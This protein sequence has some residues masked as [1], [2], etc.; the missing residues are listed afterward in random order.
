MKK[1]GFIDYYIDEWHAD[2]YPT[3]I[4]NSSY[5]DKFQ[6]AL[7]WEQASL[8]GKKSIDQW[9]AEQGV[10]KARS[11]DQVIEECDCIVVLSPDNPE[12]HESLTDLPLRSGK[13]VYVDKTFAPSLA[14]ARR[15][16]ENAKA[17]NTPMMTSSALRYDSTVDSA[18]QTIGDQPVKFVSLR[19][20]GVWEIYAIHQ[21]EPL[22]RIIGAGA[23]RLM[24]CGNAGAKLVVIDY[25][26][27]RRAVVNQIPNS[28]FQFDVS[29]GDGG[30]VVVNSM[31]DFFPRFIEAMCAFFETGK[32]SAPLEQTLEVAA[33]LEAGASALQHPDEWVAV[34]K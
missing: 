8:P 18:M 4:K 19:G 12:Q 21:V 20:P 3:F 10:A 14:A 9:C 1:I 17:H 25:A 27:G 13:P 7:A 31:D 30:I 22:T 32:S 15:M 26:D 16:V 28:P 2:N 24:Q 11:M 5:A 34:P 29:Y 23:K 6:V 33:I